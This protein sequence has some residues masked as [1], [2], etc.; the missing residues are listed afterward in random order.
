MPLPLE[1][2]RLV[3]ALRQGILDAIGDN[4]TGVYLCGSLAL[5]DFDPQTSDVDLLVV[6]G[7]PVSDPEM[8]ALADLHQHIS[9]T[10][11]RF[12]QEYEVYYI[13]RAT[14]RRFAPG[15]VHVKIGPDDPF[16]WTEHRP[17]WV[18]E[19]WVVREHGVVLSGPDP[20]T[21]ID[22]VSPDGLREAAAGEIRVR[23]QNWNDS[24]WPLTEMAHRGSQG[25]EVET[26]CRALYTI[27]TGEV[28]SKR[29]SVEWAIDVLP[30]RWHGLVEWSQRCRKDLTRDEGR[31]PEVLDFL[32][33]AV[34]EP[35]RRRE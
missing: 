17:G 22:A 12:S 32:R 34:A 13:D 15:Q 14:I 2:K 31:V 27:A 5:G 25:F 21:L 26:V 10:G 28:S 9:P 35:E 4:L 19:R 1:V 18:I 3:E 24:T 6:T 23:L 33:W 11:N 29:R 16:Q 20:R 30:E 8:R 7:R